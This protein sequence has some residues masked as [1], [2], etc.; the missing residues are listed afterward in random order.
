VLLEEVKK[1]AEMKPTMW[2]N[3][4]GIWKKRRLHIVLPVV[5]GDQKLQDYLCGRRAINSRSAGHIHCGCMGLAVNETTVGPG[6]LLHGGCKKP[7]TQVL[8]RLNNLALMD[9]SDNAI[10]GPVTLVEQLLPVESRKDWKEKCLVFDHLCCVKRFSKNILGKVFSMHA[11][12]NAFDGIDFSTNE[13]GIL[14]A[15]AEDH[16][17]SCESGIMFHLAEVAYRGLT[18]SERAEFEEIIR[19]KVWGCKSIILAEYPRGTLKTDFGKL[20]LCSHEEKVGTVFYLL[21]ALHDK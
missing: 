4:G 14:V 18:N 2:V 19:T 8:N 6:S 15:T 12:Q 5:L 9:V 3:L 20:T 17:H 1:V 11:H 16:L 13:H 21:I 10:S 7:P